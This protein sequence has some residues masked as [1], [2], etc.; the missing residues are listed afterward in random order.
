MIQSMNTLPRTMLYCPAGVCPYLLQDSI[1]SIFNKFVS[2]HTLREIPLCS[3]YDMY[4][5]GCALPFSSSSSDD[6]ITLNMPFSNGCFN[7]QLSS[8]LSKTSHRRH[9]TKDGIAI[10]TASGKQLITPNEY[11]SIIDFYQPKL[12][13]TLFDYEYAADLSDKSKTK[14]IDRS[15]D[16][17]LESKTKSFLSLIGGSDIS[18][19]KRYIDKLIEAN[20]ELKNFEGIVYEGIDFSENSIEHIIKCLSIYSAN[21]LPLYKCILNPISPLQ[22]A[23]L[24]PYA[25]LFSGLYPLQL[26]GNALN[27][28]LLTSKGPVPI[29]A[30]DSSTCECPVCSQIS[31][32]YWM[33]LIDAKEILG[34]TYCVMHNIFS[35]CTFFADMRDSITAN[36]FELYLQRLES[37]FIE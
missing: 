30:Y 33:H 28:K 31:K 12:H 1:S 22:A 27:P 5:A 20:I 21:D 24:Y 3:I 34:K 14:C 7:D 32:Q 25:N 35:Y 29:G 19:R 37:V 2:M 26:L 6:F 8:R 23:R 11:E 10:W 16:Y 18:K 4:K 17:V 13:Q 36:T 9:N 15:V